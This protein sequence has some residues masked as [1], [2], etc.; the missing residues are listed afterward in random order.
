MP[1]N[2][3]GLA[4]ITHQSPLERNDLI[5]EWSL[6]PQ[7]VAGDQVLVDKSENSQRTP[8]RERDHKSSRASS[9]GVLVLQQVHIFSQQHSFSRTLCL[10][11]T[12]PDS[13]KSPVP[14]PINL[15]NR[16]LKPRLPCPKPIEIWHRILSEPQYSN[17]CDNP[18]A[19]AA[20]TL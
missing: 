13:S 6:L 17:I 7:H 12:R 10:S 8:L 14:Q 9:Y 1:V 19:P 4:H 5:V 15:H 18:L 16:N 2:C 3:H 11:M 20:A